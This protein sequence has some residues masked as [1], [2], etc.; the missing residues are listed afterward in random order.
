[1]NPRS[2]ALLLILILA[3]PSSAWGNAQPPWRAGSVAGEPNGLEAVVIET[4]TLKIDLRPLADGKPALVEATY[5]LRNDGETRTTELVFVTGSS[6][7]E[8][9]SVKLN[10]ADV[11]HT[12]TALESMPAEWQP[13]KKTPRIGGGEG[14]PYH[15]RKDKGTL[16]AFR[17]SLAPGANVLQVRYATQASAWS[18]SEPTRYW[19]LAYILAPARAWGGFDKLQVTVQLPPGW[20]AA[21]EPGLTRDG[22]ELTG[23]FKGIPAAALALT[24]QSPPPDPA[25]TWARPAAAGVS[26]LAAVI[27]GL[28]LTW[29]LGIDAGR[30]LARRGR[31]VWWALPGGA[32]A[33]IVWSALLIG[34]TFVSIV[35]DPEGRGIPESQRA[36]NRGAGGGLALLVLSLFCL[37]A[38]PLGLVLTQIAAFWARRRMTSA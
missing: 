1:M 9:T 22:D 23:I 32:V 6:L 8:L 25:P 30:W 31:S 33:G 4:E 29:R 34:A 10:D 26:W 36:W 17:V 24:V 15:F 20:R 3:L 14:V 5:R 18:G 7:G 37:A 38:V 21:S 27:G 11:A 19:Q 35:F 12:R 28:I 16:L 13:P 2:V